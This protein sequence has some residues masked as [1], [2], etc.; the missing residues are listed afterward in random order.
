MRRA[1]YRTI[2][3][4][5]GWVFVQD[6]GPWD[7]HPTVTND[8]ENVVADLVVAGELPPGRRLFYIDSEGQVDEL[9]VAEGQFAGF[10]PGPYR[11]PLDNP[12]AQTGKEIMAHAEQE[13][14]TGVHLEAS[15][16]AA[17]WINEHADTY[18]LMVETAALSHGGVIR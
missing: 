12:D 16:R 5:S 3:S 7:E 2:A 15:T 4:L 1:R 6:I 8:A 13:A 14:R 10:A 11:L 9:L 17:R 18:R